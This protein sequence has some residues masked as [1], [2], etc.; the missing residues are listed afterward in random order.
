MI[1]GHYRAN[2]RDFPWR[3]TSEPYKILVSE[4]MLQQT[5]TFRVLPKYKEFIKAL[6]DFRSLSHVPLPTLLRLWSGMG[7]NRRALN[8]KK[9]AQI[10]MEKYG[11]K[12]P[13]D[14]ELLQELPGIGPGT[15]G[16]ICAFAFNLP[17]AFIETN[18]RRAFI[19]SFFSGE[20]Q[21]SGGHVVIP[22]SSEGG[23]ASGGKA[24]ILTRKY[25]KIP[26]FLPSTAVG[27][28]AMTRR[29]SDADI[30]KL[31]AATVDKKNPREWYYALMDYGAMLAKQAPNPN[32]RSTHYAVQSTF[33]GSNRELRGK[34]LRRL[35][36]AR[37]YSAQELA[38]V[39]HES[40]SRMRKVLAE[41]E[42]EQFLNIRGNTIEI[43]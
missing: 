9:T 28:Q 36:Q 24:G 14:P 6:P 39:M 25:H 31:V 11:G 2:R 19:H 8:L 15:A 20:L 23:S 43:R 41:L 12:L 4:V 26:A 7:Y 37:V 17:V 10:V 33:K 3:R 32:R 1:L 5:Q 27:A 42:E 22:A 29:V 16:A 38:A 21:N 40:V 30:L 13:R 34:I 35:I 18:I